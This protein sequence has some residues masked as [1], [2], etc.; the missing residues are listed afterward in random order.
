VA[1]S[2]V[3]SN[4][5][6]KWPRIFSALL[7]VVVAAVVWL[8]VAVWDL[9]NTVACPQATTDCTVSVTRTPDTNV[10]VALLIV[11]AVALLAAATG[12]MWT[13]S[14]GGATFTPSAATVNVSSSTQTEVDKAAP[15]STSRPKVVA[16]KTKSVDL[17]QELPLD[18]STAAAYGWR[19]EHPGLR[20][21]D[22]LREW[23]V[24]SP[25][26]GPPTYF[27]RAADPTGAESWLKVTEPA[28][29]SISSLTINRT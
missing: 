23:R 26:S 24:T 4:E 18:V 9:K 29:S 22:G 12:R 21:S 17:F 10:V 13:I 16:G 20:L 5:L 1:S 19:R 11:A 8:Y 25:T 14:L 6:G 3:S 7:G 27:L 2:G 28:P 15:A